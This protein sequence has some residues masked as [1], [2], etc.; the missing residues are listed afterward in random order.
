MGH[1]AQ[2][3]ENLSLEAVSVTFFGKKLL[4]QK[5]ILFSL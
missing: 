4:T 5:T 3:N 1:I 2:F